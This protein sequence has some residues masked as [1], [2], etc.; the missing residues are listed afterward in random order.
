MQH[1]AFGAHG[2]DE[3]G[4]FDTL[5]AQQVQ[6]VV[7]SA[8]TFAVGAALPLLMVLCLP[9]SALVWGLAGRSLFFLAL[10]GLV[11]SRTGGAHR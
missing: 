5:S 10:L 7:A 11:A 8:G 1:D 6:S 9:I 2:R 3:L 4:I